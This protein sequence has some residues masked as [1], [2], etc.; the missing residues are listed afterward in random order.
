VLA[1]GGTTGQLS[2]PRRMNH[3]DGAHPRQQ[4]IGDLGGP[5][6]DLRERP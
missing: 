6:D 4:F 5:A 1:N 3:M 2:A